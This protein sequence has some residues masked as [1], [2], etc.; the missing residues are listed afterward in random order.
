[1]ALSRH[2]SADPGCWLT[3]NFP[4]GGRKEGVDP[5]AAAAPALEP[6]QDADA[7]AQRGEQ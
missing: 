1:M 7:V 6:A 2:P 5:S 3:L 4:E